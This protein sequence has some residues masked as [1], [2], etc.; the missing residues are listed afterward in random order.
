[1]PSRVLP[2]E[3]GG[4]SDDPALDDCISSLDFLLGLRFQS[5]VWSIFHQP[6]NCLPSN[7]SS[8]FILVASFGRCKLRLSGLNVGY[9]LQS[10][11][12]GSAL[13]FKI[14]FLSERVF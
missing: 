12:G 7:S 5:S 11:L 4:A 8:S 3:K 1:V 13:D 6:I 9:I 14:V 2:V 10:I